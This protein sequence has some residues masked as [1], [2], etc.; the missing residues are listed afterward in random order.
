MVADIERPLLFKI[1]GSAPVIIHEKFDFMLKV[2]IKSKIKW[3]LLLVLPHNQHQKIFG[4][5]YFYNFWFCLSQVA[6]TFLFSLTLCWIGIT[7]S[8]L[9][10]S[11]NLLIIQFTYSSI[12]SPLMY[13]NKVCFHFC[14]ILETFKTFQ[15]F[16]SSQ[17]AL[18]IK[19]HIANFELVCFN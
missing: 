4:S 5:S 9:W 7:T 16:E 1:S 18:L 2:F 13:T 14:L 17:I 10:F 11:M 8:N 3:V 19:D 12:F 15:N 6:S